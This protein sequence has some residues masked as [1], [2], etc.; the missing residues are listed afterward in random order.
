M[1]TFKASRWEK[2]EWSFDSKQTVVVNDSKSLV[3][4]ILWFFSCTFIT[5]DDC[6]WGFRHPWSWLY[7]AGYFSYLVN[8]SNVGFALKYHF[9]LLYASQIAW[10]L[11]NPQ[12]KPSW[13]NVRPLLIDVCFVFA[14]TSETLEFYEQLKEMKASPTLPTFI[15]NNLLTLYGCHGKLL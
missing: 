9:E 3:V 10:S 1:W 4:L 2:F 12:F 11:G 14:S 8:C 13:R 15:Y 5:Y 7:P 6:P